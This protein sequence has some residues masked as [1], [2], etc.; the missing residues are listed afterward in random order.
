MI[1][2]RKYSPLRA[3]CERV[4]PLSASA[5]GQALMIFPNLETP[6]LGTPK[7]QRMARCR[8]GRSHRTSN[9][10]A[11]CDGS[12]PQM[13]TSVAIATRN[14]PSTVFSVKCLH[15]GNRGRTAE[16]VAALA[17]TV[18]ASAWGHLNGAATDF[19]LIIYPLSIHSAVRSSP[20]PQGELRVASS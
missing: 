6:R 7:F 10:V 15:L 13:G 8:T 16:F 2:S 4:C 12:L 9:F 1:H 19:C 11:L 3:R 17:G 5:F 14:P 20:L 18:P